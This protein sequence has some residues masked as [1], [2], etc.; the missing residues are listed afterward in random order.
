MINNTSK[1]QQSEKS[2]EHDNDYDTWPWKY[3][4]DLE[5]TQTHGGVKPAGAKPI[6]ISW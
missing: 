3:G 5:Q 4:R 1:N 2:H 6:L